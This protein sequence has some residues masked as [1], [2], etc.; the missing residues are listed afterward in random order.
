MPRS[1]RIILVMLILAVGFIP[2]SA[3]V[4]PYGSLSVQEK[5]ALEQSEKRLQ[6]LD[7]ALESLELNYEQKKIRARDYAA[8]K[9]DLTAFIS[10]EAQFQ[11]DLLV[12]SPEMTEDHREILQNIARYAVLVP[13]YLVAILAKGFVSSGSSY[14]FTP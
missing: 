3:S 13:T 5:L 1:P 6:T 14:S 10:A 2:A 7:Q 9:H 4:R 11:N 8:T 12:K